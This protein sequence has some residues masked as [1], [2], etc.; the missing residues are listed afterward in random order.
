MS[1][2]SEFLGKKKGDIISLSTGQTMTDH[3]EFELE[4]IIIETRVYHEPNGMFTYTG[5]LCKPQNRD[6]MT[7]MFLIRQVDA[8]FDLMLYY[9][10]NDGSIVEAREMVLTD[11]GQDLV[12]QFCID[13]PFSNG[14]SHPVNWTKKAAGSFFGIEFTDPD[15]TGITTICE[16]QTDDP[17]GENPHGF[18]DWKGDAEDGWVEFWMGSPVQPFEVKFFAGETL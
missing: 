17:C 13:I 6:D 10:N 11:D 15:N 4:M 1:K 8:D 16:Y 18:M 5:Y 12:P 9:L 3:N 2:V 14:E 7:Y